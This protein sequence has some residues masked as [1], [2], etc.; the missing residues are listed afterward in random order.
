MF[1]TYTFSNVERVKKSAREL[2]QKRRTLEICAYICTHVYIMHNTRPGYFL[3]FLWH[4]HSHCQMH[5]QYK[6]SL[7]ISYCLSTAS[8]RN[9]HHLTYI[10]LRTRLYAHRHLRRCLPIYIFSLKNWWFLLVTE[11]STSLSLS[12]FCP[13][14]WSTIASPFH[15]H[16]HLSLNIYVYN[17]I[18]SH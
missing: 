16:S 12:T 13:F 6:K 7:C 2:R 18:F 4:S 5:R 10:C 8:D 15:A 9:H 1:I 17:T 11:L 3:S 14:C